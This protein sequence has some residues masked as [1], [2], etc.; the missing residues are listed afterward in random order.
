MVSFYVMTPSGFEVEYGWGGRLID[1]AVWQ[2]VR[3]R[4]GNIWGHRS[5]RVPVREPVPAGVTHG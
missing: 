1:D 2:V 5:R 3:H 4:N